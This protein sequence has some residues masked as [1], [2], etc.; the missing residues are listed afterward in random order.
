[1]V[2]LPRYLLLLMLRL[3]AAA[4]AACQL[5]VCLLGLTKFSRMQDQAALQRHVNAA[6]AVS[7]NHSSLWSTFRVKPSR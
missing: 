2:T 4:A 1:M 6:K 7:V 3:Y 5:C